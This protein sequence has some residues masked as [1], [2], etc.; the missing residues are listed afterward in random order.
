MA[1]QEASPDCWP[2]FAKN[3]AQEVRS[4]GG[5]FILQVAG[6]WR[7]ALCFVCLH[8][9]KDLC[10]WGKSSEDEFRAWT[11]AREGEAGR[12]VRGAPVVEETIPRQNPQNL[13]LARVWAEE[14]GQRRC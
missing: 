8:L 10:R 7:S 14:V 1:E 11:G 5:D 3:K 2:V 4:E 6:S 12:E 9:N 13:V